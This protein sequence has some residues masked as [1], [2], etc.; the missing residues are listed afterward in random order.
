MV[1]IYK[2]K[3]DF[4][5]NLLK[6]FLVRVY[7]NLINCSKII[8]IKDSDSGIDQNVAYKTIGEIYNISDNN[9]KE[10]TFCR[11]LYLKYKFNNNDANKKEYD[12]KIRN[13]EADYSMF[14]NNIDRYT[15][16]N[17][18]QTKYTDSEDKPETDSETESNDSYSQDEDDGDW[19][20]YVRAGGEKIKKFKRS[21]KSRRFRKTKRSRK[22]RRR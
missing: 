22:T 12:K 16:K 9:N 5:N 1:N 10:L 7:Y 4:Y 17:K 18:T 6:S 3:R 19:W 14:I 8:N 11:L 2:L 13:I 21:R 20:E 15:R